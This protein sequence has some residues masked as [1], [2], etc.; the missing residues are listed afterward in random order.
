MAGFHLFSSNT[1]NVIFFWC[2]LLFSPKYKTLLL[3]FLTVFFYFVLHLSI[4]DEHSETREYLL[5]LL[6]GTDPCT[7]SPLVTCTDDDTETWS[8]QA[9]SS[10][11]VM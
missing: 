8:L 11:T 5:Q 6:S 1:E 2:N 7:S 4:I 10:C 9:D 3:P